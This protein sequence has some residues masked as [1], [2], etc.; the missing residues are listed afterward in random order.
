VEKQVLVR[1]M[2][3]T[4]S[5][6]PVVLSLGQ[7]RL[8]VL[9]DTVMMV[10]ALTVVALLLL[11]DVGWANRTN[12]VIWLVFVADYVARL[13]LSTDRRAF[14]KANVVDL[15][16]ILPADQFRALRLLRL[17]R[18]LR[19]VSVLTRVMGDL[20]GIRDTN[21]LGWVLAV[22]GGVVTA[23]AVA[24]RMLESS[25]SSWADAFWWAIVTATTV[26][27]GDISPETTGAR[28]V[29]VLLM[30]VGIGTIGMLTATIATYFLGGTTTPS[31]VHVEH[32]QSLLGRW[33][34][35]TSEDRRAAA[36]LLWAI[37][38]PEVSD[39]NRPV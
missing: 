14:V 24:V 16:A 10:L 23:G 1:G 12:L 15:L 31:S 3:V 33:D 2:Q 20:R 22:A 39:S 5:R 18:L 13:L 9:Y 8:R 11:D 37:A 7:G 29:A 26:G 32:L 36:E 6:Q 4:L 35:L 38:H 19:A 30:L 25:V 28:A 27:Y 34:E 21:G 17:L